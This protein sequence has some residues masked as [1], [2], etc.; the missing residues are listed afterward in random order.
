MLK[1]IDGINE[2]DIFDFIDLVPETE[3]DDADIDLQLEEEVRE[4]EA[5]K[6]KLKNYCSKS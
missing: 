5:G 3:I 6:H 2:I 1:L 4:K